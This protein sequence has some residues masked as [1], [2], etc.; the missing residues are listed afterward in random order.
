[1]K[2]VISMFLSILCFAACAGSV[3][4]ATPAEDELG[5]SF[6]YQAMSLPSQEEIQ[7][8]EARAAEM[9]RIVELLGL[10]HSDSSVR[11]NR[12]VD[13]EEQEEAKTIMEKYSSEWGA[14]SIFDQLA[15]R[16]DSSTLALDLPVVAQETGYY[17]GPASAYMVLKYE[18]PNLNVT[19]QTLAG[20]AYLN[21]TTSGTDFSTNWTTT[22]NAFSDHE[23]ALLW[24]FSN[25]SDER[26]IL[27]TDC[28]IATLTAGYGVIYDTVQYTTKTERLVGYPSA[29][30][31]NVYHYV[32]GRGYDVSDPYRRI[33]YYVDPN[34]AREDAYGEQ[35]IRFRLLCTLMSTRGLVY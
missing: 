12:M 7:E 27:M 18:N 32:A 23:Y 22:M 10:G 17:C 24:G 30:S 28:A 9:H 19:Q 13:A 11:T 8:S 6:G 5:L 20:S 2:R 4:A 16:T 21:T 35:E 26:A 31:S 15:A 25:D 34:G 3:F 1:M 33:C 14:V 29:L